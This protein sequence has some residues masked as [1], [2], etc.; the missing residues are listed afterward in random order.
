MHSLQRSADPSVDASTQQCERL[1][2]APNAADRARGRGD[3]HVGLVATP[4]CLLLVGAFNPMGRV[5]AVRRLGANSPSNSSLS[6]LAAQ[7]MNS[8]PHWWMG[9]VTSDRRYAS[10]AGGGSRL[11]LL[12][13]DQLQRRGGTGLDRRC[14]Y[15]GGLRRR[16][17]AVAGAAHSIQAARRDAAARL[18]GDGRCRPLHAAAP[19]CDRLG[20]VDRRGRGVAFAVSA[21]IQPRSE[22]PA[23]PERR[24]GRHAAAVER[25][26]AGRV[27]QRRRADIA[28]RCRRRRQRSFRRYPRSRRRARS[29][30]SFPP[31]NPRKLR[32][33][34]RPPRRSIRHCSRSPRRDRRMPRTWRR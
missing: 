22:Q 7:Q 28:G 20:D 2:L 15:G 24:G 9:R 18:W 21:Q 32:P 5:A 34:R 11:S 12:C 17:D 33:S 31:I 3:D 30:V 16:Y 27:Q 6:L 23:N 25:Q 14:R 10:S 13:A 19:L 4:E 29:T 8:S 26:P 1:W